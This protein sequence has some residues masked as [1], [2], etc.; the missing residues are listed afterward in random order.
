MTK[1]SNKKRKFTSVFKVKPEDQKSKLYV[2]T[3]EKKEKLYT[4]GFEKSIALMKELCKQMKHIEFADGSVTVCFYKNNIPYI[5]ENYDE[6]RVVLKKKP[7]PMFDISKMRDF[8]HEDMEAD[9][10]EH[11]SV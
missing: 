9:V 5:M 1:S 11:A 2:P 7:R 6:C 3:S 10:H 4:P 8:H